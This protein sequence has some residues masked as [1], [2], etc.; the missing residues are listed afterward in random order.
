LS[1]Q[2]DRLD[3]YEVQARFALATM[4]DKAASGQPAPKPAPPPGAPQ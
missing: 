1:D 2:K 3:T 4:Y